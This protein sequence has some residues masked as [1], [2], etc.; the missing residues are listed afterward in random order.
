MLAEVVAGV[1]AQGVSTGVLHDDGGVLN[2]LI[3]RPTMTLSEAVAEA[4]AA[5]AEG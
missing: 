4:L 1:E 2:Q 5:H 3:G